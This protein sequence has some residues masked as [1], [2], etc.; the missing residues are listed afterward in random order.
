MI[1]N[2]KKYILYAFLLNLAMGVVFVATGFIIGKGTFYLGTDY[3]YQ[4]ILFGQMAR[5]NILAG[6]F[7][8]Y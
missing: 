1:K 4:Q 8:L 2:E 5:D 3:N 7:I 6:N